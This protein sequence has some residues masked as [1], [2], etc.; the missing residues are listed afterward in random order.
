MNMMRFSS[1]I[2]V[3]GSLLLITAIVSGAGN[4]PAVKRPPLVLEMVSLESNGPTTNEGLDVE[5]LKLMKGKELSRI[6]ALATQDGPFL[7]EASVADHVIRFEGKLK[8][9]DDKSYRVEIKYSDKS[10]SRIQCITS[11]IMLA[12]DEQKPV[13]GMNAANYRSLLVF[14][15]REHKPDEKK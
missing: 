7:A 12:L 3:I 15:L 6:E 10:P 1:V 13:G 2:V 5:P 9:T 11:T 14:S 4:E 8:S